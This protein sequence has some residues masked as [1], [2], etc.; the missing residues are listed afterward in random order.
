MPHSWFNL[1]SHTDDV[2]FRV[3]SLP[4]VVF[5]FYK[6][7][8]F[9]VCTLILLYL[10]AIRSVFTNA[11][12][13]VLSFYSLSPS[14]IFFLPSSNDKTLVDHFISFSVTWHSNCLIYKHCLLFVVVFLSRTNDWALQLLPEIPLLFQTNKVCFVILRNCFVYQMTP[15]YC[16]NFTLLQKK[17][18][19]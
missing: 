4:F 1:F 11:K 15:A 2:W 5:Y 10:R 17:S 3:T 13:E 7:M 19:I 8:K 9:P 18:F 12:G 14:F 6:I 16:L